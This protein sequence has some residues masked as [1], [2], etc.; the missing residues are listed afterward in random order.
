MRQRAGGREGRRWPVGA[1]VGP[2][3]LSVSNPMTP[4]DCRERGS[5]SNKAPEKG[6]HLSCQGVL[7]KISGG[8]TNVSEGS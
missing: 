6:E 4:T 8:Q 3:P 2:V 5:N 1:E 7:G